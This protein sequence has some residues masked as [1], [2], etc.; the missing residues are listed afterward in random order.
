VDAPL[1]TIAV[2]TTYEKG[3]WNATGDA[4]IGWVAYG[5]IMAGGRN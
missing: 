1:K 2:S 3:I 5:T 4:V